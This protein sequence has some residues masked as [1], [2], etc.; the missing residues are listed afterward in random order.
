MEEETMKKKL[1]VI[2]DRAGV[3]NIPLAEII[4]FE[5]QGSYSITHTTTGKKYISCKSLRAIYKEISEAEDFCRIHHSH[6]INLTRIKTYIRVNGMVVMTD[7]SEV[8]VSRRRKHNFFKIYIK[9]YSTTY[10]KSDQLQNK[11]SQLQNTT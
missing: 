7:G 1:L 5:S 8:P 10:K 4:R 3:H 11:H 9:Q 6:I 2:S